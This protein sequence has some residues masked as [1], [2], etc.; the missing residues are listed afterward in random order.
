MIDPG[1]NSAKNKKFFLSKIVPK[2]S[3]T[4]QIE[5]KKDRKGRLKYK[6][7]LLAFKILFKDQIKVEIEI[8]NP[9]M[10]MKEIK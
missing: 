9:R 3:K 4:K 10:S 7:D 6:I 8:A 1:M 5:I 2:K